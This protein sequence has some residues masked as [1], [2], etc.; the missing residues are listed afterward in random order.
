MNNERNETRL[1]QSL[2]SGVTVLSKTLKSVVFCAA[3][4]MVSWAGGS[5]C[6][7][8]TRSTATKTL[9]AQRL[10]Q[11]VVLNPGRM[12]AD[13]LRFRPQLVQVS[14]LYA[15]KHYRR[16]LVVFYRYYLNKFAAPQHYGL[17]SALASPYLAWSCRP[18][19]CVPPLFSTHTPIKAVERRPMNW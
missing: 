3:V 13:G 17:P 7:A 14:K 5:R 18:F 10:L 16:A 15:E 12:N 4:L 9:A 6:V 2:F 8:A 19:W 1:I 11:M